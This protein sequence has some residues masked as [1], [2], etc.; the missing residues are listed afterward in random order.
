MLL[1]VITR[2]VAEVDGMLESPVTAEC[3]QKAVVDQLRIELSAALVLLDEPILQR[4]S[5]SVP[6]KMT[7]SDGQ[8]PKMTIQISS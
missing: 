3:I 6:L 1:Q 4:G 8:R 7:F 5:H 2:P